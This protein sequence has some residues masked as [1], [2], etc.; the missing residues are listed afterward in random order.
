MKIDDIAE[1]LGSAANIVKRTW[2][3]NE[4]ARTG[5]RKKNYILTKLKLSKNVNNSLHK[6]EPFLF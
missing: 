1:L 3:Q 5:K 4:N 6:C 2:L